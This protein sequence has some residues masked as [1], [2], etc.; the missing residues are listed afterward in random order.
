MARVPGFYRRGKGQVRV[1]SPASASPGPV[2][3]SSRGWAWFWSVVAP[4][5]GVAAIRHTT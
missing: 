1:K 2:E 3:P 4:R 5:A